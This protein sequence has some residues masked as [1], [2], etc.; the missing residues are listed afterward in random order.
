MKLLVNKLSLALFFSNLAMTAFASSSTSLTKGAM[1]AAM[2]IFDIEE[3]WVSITTIYWLPKLLVLAEC[4]TSKEVIQNITVYTVSLCLK[5]VDF[6][7]LEKVVD[8]L[9]DKLEEESLEVKIN[10][11]K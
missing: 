6:C 1:L 9:A 5:L 8:G 2:K 11:L 7:G 3:V 4:R 10:Q